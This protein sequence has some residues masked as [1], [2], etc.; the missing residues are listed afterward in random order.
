M[1]FFFN[2]S[3]FSLL[4]LLFLLFSKREDPGLNN[5]KVAQSLSDYFFH[6]WFCEP[7]IKLNESEGLLRPRQS[8][9]GIQKKKRR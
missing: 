4:L 6:Y 3:I 8:Y 2:T 1:I 7:F 9:Q 5:V